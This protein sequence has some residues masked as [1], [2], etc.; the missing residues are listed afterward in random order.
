MGELVGT[1]AGTPQKFSGRVSGHTLETQ[2]ASERARPGN[3]G[4]ESAGKPVG[5]LVVT[6]PCLLKPPQELVVTRRFVLLIKPA[7]QSDWPLRVPV[8]TSC[9]VTASPSVTTPWS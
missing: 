3:L 2:G 4:G 9:A 7:D 5:E 6:S 8:A 1:L